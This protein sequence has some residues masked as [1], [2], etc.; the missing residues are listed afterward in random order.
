[1][2]SLSQGAPSFWTRMLVDDRDPLA[3]MYSFD[4]QAA[5]RSLRYLAELV[6]PDTVELTVEAS[7]KIDLLDSIRDSKG[8]LLRQ[9]LWDQRA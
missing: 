3:A 4:Q 1:V 9:D 6:K 8:E 7:R 2:D 5:K